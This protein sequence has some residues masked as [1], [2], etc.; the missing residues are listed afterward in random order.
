MTPPP[1]PFWLS[2]SLVAAAV[3]AA[4][5]VPDPAPPAA[6]GDDGAFV[7]R[8]G[9]DTVSVERYTLSPEG[10]EVLA[11]SRSPRALLREATL[12]LDGEG[13]ITRYETRTTDPSAPD[14][15]PLQRMVVTYEA[16]SVTVETGT[17]DE[18]RT[19][20]MAGGPDMVP[21]SLNH[22]SL[23][24]L[25]IR[26][27]MVADEDRIQMWSNGPMPVEVHRPAADSVALD[28]G[29]LGTWRAHVD[30]EGRMLGMQAGA[31]GRDIERAPGLDVEALARHWAEADARGEGMGP[32]SPRDTLQTTVAGAGIT[33]DYSRPAAR[34][35][36]VF[37][38]LVPYG[39]VWRTG[40]DQATHFSTE[41][42]LE[43][44]GETIPAGTYTLFTI[45]EEQRWT[46][47]VNR[48][49]GQ[50]GTQHDPEMDLLRA[51]MEVLGLETHENRFTILVEET[52][53]GG[54]LR[55]I[56]EETEARVPFQVEGGG[57][58]TGRP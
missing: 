17:G 42:N 40:A 4:C 26:R 49:T 43:M 14:D 12:E 10:M 37:G 6:A 33:V 48:E 35:R 46:L 52:D 31:L 21:F 2:V 19:Q 51:E 41:R 7:V 53:E 13:D 34:G 55:M 29:T 44:A 28:T 45:P 1:R 18:A 58:G 57:G 3:L 47:V 36:Q 38:G 9:T 15:E 27:A 22:F 5:E 39:E 56:W 25:A 32:L 20:R 24:E 30:D 11:V 50:P 8:L 54:V 23:A 16:D